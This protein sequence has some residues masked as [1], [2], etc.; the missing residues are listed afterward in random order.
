VIKHW[1]VWP[2]NL[3]LPSCLNGTSTIYLMPHKLS[4]FKYQNFS[5]HNV[6]KGNIDKLF[7]KSKGWQTAG[8]CEKIVHTL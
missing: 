7:K 3:A 2:Y 4:N 1:F 8:L 5:H 6:G